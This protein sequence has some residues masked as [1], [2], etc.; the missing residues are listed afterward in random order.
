M[1][2]YD[3]CRHEDAAIDGLCS[4]HIILAVTA[5]TLLATPAKIGCKSNECGTK[6]KVLPWKTALPRTSETEGA[7]LNLVVYGR[8]SLSDGGSQSQRPPLIMLPLGR[9]PH[10]AGILCAG[11]SVQP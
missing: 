10:H 8:W 5:E 3:D 7:I 9:F 11:T 2:K 1:T 4:F 6:A